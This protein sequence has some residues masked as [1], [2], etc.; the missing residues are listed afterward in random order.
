VKRSEEPHSIAL[1]TSRI[2]RATAVHDAVTVII[3]LTPERALELLELMREII[4][5]ARY[6]SKTF[7]ISSFEPD[8]LYVP[9]YALSKRSRTRDFLVLEN[10]FLVTTRDLQVREYYS[11]PAITAFV[12]ILVSAKRIKHKES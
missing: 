5:R 11:R 12:I 7:K 2:P 4:A 8:A 9:S 6:S 1:S 10:A 3:K